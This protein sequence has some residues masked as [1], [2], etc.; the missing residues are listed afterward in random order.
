MGWILDGW[1]ES[2]GSI[3]F[4]TILRPAVGL[5]R[6]LTIQEEWSRL[7][8][9]HSTPYSTKVTSAWKCVSLHTR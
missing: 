3:P 5:A 2:W 8:S 6:A 9:H 4:A 7:E 1:L